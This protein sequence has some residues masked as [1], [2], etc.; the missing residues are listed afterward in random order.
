MIK[1]SKVDVQNIN[2]TCNIKHSGIADIDGDKKL[3]PLRI[4][5]WEITWNNL[6][7]FAECVADE[8]GCGFEMS[9]SQYDDDI[10][11]NEEPYE[12]VQV[13]E[14][15]EDTSVIL[16]RNAYHELALRFLDFCIEIAKKED[17]PIYKGPKWSELLHYHELIR[18]KVRLNSHS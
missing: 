12:G 4:F 18:K 15:M 1:I 5:F 14:Y 3:R 7:F 2:F 13:T 6:L 8:V 10:E 9:G 17:Q 11:P 16:S